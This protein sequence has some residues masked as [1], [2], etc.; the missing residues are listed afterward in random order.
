MHVYILCI[1]SQSAHPSGQPEKSGRQTSVPVPPVDI[2]QVLLVPPV[3]IIDILQILSTKFHTSSPLAPTPCQTSPMIRATS[4]RELTRQIL[5]SKLSQ[6]QQEKNY[7]KI[8]QKQKSNWTKGIIWQKYLTTGYNK[9]DVTL[10]ETSRF[11][12]QLVAA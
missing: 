12:P 3:I 8:K 5:F 4:D 1:Y 2:V 11:F 7:R 9:A 10:P 6:N